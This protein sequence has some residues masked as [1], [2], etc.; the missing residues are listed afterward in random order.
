MNRTCRNEKYIQNVSQDNLQGRD[1]LGG[2]IEVDG[3]IL[4]WMLKK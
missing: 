4:K 2:G 1:H 3:I